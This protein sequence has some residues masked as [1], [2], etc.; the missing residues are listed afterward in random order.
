VDDVSFAVHLLATHNCVFAVRSGGHMSWAGAA[1]V[2]NG[3]TI[4]LSS[5]NQVTVSKDHTIS[6][7]GSGARWEDVYLKLD[8]LGLAVAG[9]R[10]ADVGVG[11]LVT[12]GRTSTALS[13][14][15][16]FANDPSIGGNSFFA[17][18][19]G[20]ACDNVENFEVCTLRCERIDLNVS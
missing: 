20:F 10:V 5:I 15:S 14:M 13:V 9:G 2:E 17:A 16:Y 19:H 6:S 12:G 8:S 4:D 18:Q 11:G 1:N 7:V 3:V